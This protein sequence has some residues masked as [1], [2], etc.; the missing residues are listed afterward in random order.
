MSMLVVKNKFIM[1]LIVITLEYFYTNSN[2]TWIIFHSWNAYFTTNCDWNH[3]IHTANFLFFPNLAYFVWNQKINYLTKSCRCSKSGSIFSP[4]L[5][6][7]QL[8]LQWWYLFGQEN[9]HAMNQHYLS[10][11][12]YF[13]VN[14]LRVVRNLFFFIWLWRITNHFFK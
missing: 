9:N 12:F 5:V 6:F 13:Y 7:R 14:F 8:R 4:N 11:L 10:L 3:F 1:S 2:N